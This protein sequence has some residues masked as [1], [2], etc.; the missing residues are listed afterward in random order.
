MVDDDLSHYPIGLK[1]YLVGAMTSINLE[2]LQSV[3][4]QLKNT[5]MTKI[6]N[7]LMWLYVKSWGPRGQHVI[8]DEKLWNFGGDDLEAA[9][10]KTGYP[11]K[12]GSTDRIN[13]LTKLIIGRF[14]KMEDFYTWSKL[15]HEE[16]GI[17]YLNFN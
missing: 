4:D 10:I 13:D 1:R 11:K 7:A 16:V 14:K 15:I 8:D 12:K 9:I 6:D 2:T 5:H 17:Q 3:M